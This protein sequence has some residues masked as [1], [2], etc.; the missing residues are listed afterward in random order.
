MKHLFFRIVLILSLLV[1]TAQAQTNFMLY[2]LGCDLEENSAAGSR[3][4]LE[5]LRAERSEVEE[6]NIY[7]LTGGAH[8]WS[9]AE[10]QDES[11][12]VMRF[13]E[14]RIN[15]LH[16]LQGGACSR[17]EDV[18]RFLQLCAE[19]SPAEENIFILW[20]HGVPEENAIG[21]DALQ[22]DDLLTIAEL[23]EG[24]LHSG[25]T[26]DILGIDACGMGT[27][28]IASALQDTCHRLLAVSG[29]TP[30][31]GWPY[32]RIPALLTGDAESDYDAL[33]CTVDDFLQRDGTGVKLLNLF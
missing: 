30:L 27:E 33:Y 15:V 19:Q 4:V 18:S 2:M 29:D 11:V 21:F 5:L 25:M 17:A 3:D 13:E 24:I 31:S 20:G 26:I 28:E 23:K 16:A 8:R 22:N 6:I 10:A 12:T 14:N 7:V 32:H 9:L 1:S